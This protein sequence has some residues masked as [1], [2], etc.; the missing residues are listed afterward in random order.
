MQ[1]FIKNKKENRGLA[2]YEAKSFH[3]GFVI[4]F[5]VVLSS[6]ILAVALGVANITLKEINFSTSAK[7]TNDAFFAADTG[8]ECALYFDLAGTETAFG[9]P[10]SNPSVTNCAGTPVDLNNGAGT[11]VGPPW[12]FYL[13]PLGTGGRAC[14]VISVSRDTSAPPITTIISKGYNT[15][16]D[17]STDCTSTN[18]NRVERQIE[19]TY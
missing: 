15:G 7:N 11:P 19:L 4:L 5:A 9:I 16:G 18:P 10:M 8:A 1:N 6:I 3:S 13:Y 12:I 17:T 14:A 2:Q